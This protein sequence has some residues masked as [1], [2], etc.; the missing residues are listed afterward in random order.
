MSAALNHDKIKAPVLMQFAEQ[1]ARNAIELYARLTNSPTP[2]EMYVYPD[3]EHFKTQPR[4]MYSVH[5]R[6]L[7]WFRFWLEGH[8]D[9]KPAKAGQ[10][11]RWRELRERRTAGAT[12]ARD[13]STTD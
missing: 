8:E 1:E 11:Q 4:H 7:D 13:S 12:G 2:A 6:N 10:Y 9:S 3:A 5:Q